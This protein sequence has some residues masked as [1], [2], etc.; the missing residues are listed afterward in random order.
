MIFLL[1]SANYG[2][3]CAKFLLISNGGKKGIHMKLIKTIKSLRPIIPQKKLGYL[4]I[5]LRLG[6]YNTYISIW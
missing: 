6:M 5:I 2:E 3:F 4:K 1:L